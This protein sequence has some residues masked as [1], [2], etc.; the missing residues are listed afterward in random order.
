MLL[1]L[2]VAIRLAVRLEDFDN[3]QE[4]EDRSLRRVV[5]SLVWLVIS[6]I[7]DIPNVVRSIARYCSASIVAD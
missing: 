1:G 4:T 3:I 6:T 7:L 5:D 2:S